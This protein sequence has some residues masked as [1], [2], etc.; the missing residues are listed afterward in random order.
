MTYYALF[1]I[2]IVEMTGINTLSEK[3][4]IPFRYNFMNTT[5]KYCEYS[6]S[7]AYIEM[8]T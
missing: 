8:V 5:C 4:F 2:Q 3:L 7:K 1:E 6:K